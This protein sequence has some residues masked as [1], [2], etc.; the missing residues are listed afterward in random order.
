M[1]I[2]VTTI[3][4]VPSLSAAVPDEWW[5]ILIYSLQKY[6]WSFG[7]TV[8]LDIVR[9]CH[10]PSIDQSSCAAYR[11]FW[12]IKVDTFWLR[13]YIYILSLLELG[14]STTTC[15]YIYKWLQCMLAKVGRF[16]SRKTTDTYLF[17][18]DFE[19]STIGRPL[20]DHHDHY[21]QRAHHHHEKRML[22]GQL[23]WIRVYESLDPYFVKSIVIINLL[24]VPKTL[25]KIIKNINTM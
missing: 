21:L 5:L 7:G 15:V 3:F 1:V 14:S 6:S 13:S 9:T 17:L 24:Y 4:P 20:H 18:P 22:L 16:E 23:S 19:R 8:F 11:W 2:I 10:V 12:A 25:R